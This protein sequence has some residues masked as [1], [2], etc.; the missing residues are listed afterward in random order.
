MRESRID[1]ILLSLRRELKKRQG[2]IREAIES[3]ITYLTNGRGRMDYAR[4]EAEG[5]PIGSG[6]IE[7]TCKHLVKERFCVTGAHWRRRNIHKI[8]A[9]RLSIHNEEWNTDWET[10]L[11]A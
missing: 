2:E 4:Y 9:L 1:S 3:E 11:A 10:E 6:A 5:W 8:L 7:A